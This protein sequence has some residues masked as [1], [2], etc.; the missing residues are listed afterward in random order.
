MY[1]KQNYVLEELLS[2]TMYNLQFTNWCHCGTGISRII[3]IKLNEVVHLKNNFSK[4]KKKNVKL[5]RQN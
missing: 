5:I 4:K 1:H 2:P 3:N